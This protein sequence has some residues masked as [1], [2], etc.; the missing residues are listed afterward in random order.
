MIIKG[1]DRVLRGVLENFS[2][3]PIDKQNNF[4]SIK[5][6]IEETL[7]DKFNVYIFGSFNHG[8]WDEESDY[9]VNLIGKSNVSLNDIISQKT[10]LKVNVFFTEN[11][12][13]NIMIP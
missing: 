4:K 2:D 13:G 12:L 11:K 6:A 9:D 8:Y 1:R 3:L 10:N 7:N 5:Q